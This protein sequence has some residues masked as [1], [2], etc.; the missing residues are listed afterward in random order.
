[1]RLWPSRSKRPRDVPSDRPVEPMRDSDTIAPRVRPPSEPTGPSPEPEREAWRTLLD[2]YLP[3]LEGALPCEDERDPLSLPCPLDVLGI[4]SD[5]GAE[6]EPGQPSVDVIVCVHDALEDV[7]L[8]LWSLLAKTERRFR[9][10]VVNDGSDATTTRFLRAFAER[11]PAATLIER[12]EPPHGYTIAANRGLE[13]SE[14]RLRDPAEQR[15]GRLGRLAREA[16]RP[17]RG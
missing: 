15:H 9:L 10:I 4:L 8:C 11:H 14:E 13:A 3:L 2:S 12:E 17:W 1:M 7:R 5:A 16:H 6:Q